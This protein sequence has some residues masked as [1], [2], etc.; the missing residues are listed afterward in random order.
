MARCLNCNTSIADVDDYCEDCLS[1]I[2]STD[3]QCE[4][5]CRPLNDHAITCPENESS[6]AHLIQ[7]GYD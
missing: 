2:E 4:F 5:C 6:F 7:F 1:E 3:R